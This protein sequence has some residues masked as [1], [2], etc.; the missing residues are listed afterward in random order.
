MES[1]G[2]DGEREGFASEQAIQEMER[3][4]ALMAEIESRGL[5]Q[6]QA[7]VAIL[8]E[9]VPLLKSAAANHVPMY[10]GDAPREDAEWIVRTVAELTPGESERLQI[11]FGECLRGIVSP[12]ISRHEG[13]L[14]CLFEQVADAACTI[15]HV[16]ALDGWCSALRDWVDKLSHATRSSSLVEWIRAALRSQESVRRIVACRLFAPAVKCEGARVA[17]T[18]WR[19]LMLVRTDTSSGVALA[20]VGALGALRA[21]GGPAM[22]SVVVLPVL[23]DLVCA[24]DDAVAVAVFEQLTDMC[25]EMTDAAAVSQESAVFHSEQSLSRSKGGADG[26]PTSLKS[27]ARLLCTVVGG[28]FVNEPP[29]PVEYAV[30]SAVGPLAYNTSFLREDCGELGPGDVVLARYIERA[31]RSANVAVRLRLAHNLPGLIMAFERDAPSHTQVLLGAH[32]S[33]ATDASEDVRIQIAVAFHEVVRIVGSKY[34]RALERFLGLLDD[35]CALVKDHLLETTPRILHSLI[36]S[37]PRT[38]PQWRST[39]K[40]L[41]VTMSDYATIARTD[42][43][44]LLRLFELFDSLT[45]SVGAPELHQTYIPLLLF[46]LAAGAAAIKRH[47]ARLLARVLAATCSAENRVLLSQTIVKLLRL[48]S[49]DSCHARKGFALAVGEIGRTFSARFFSTYLATPLGRCLADSQ[50]LVRD[51]AGVELDMLPEACRSVVSDPRPSPSTSGDVPASGIAAAK[52][53]GATSEGGTSNGAKVN[54][55]FLCAP[56]VAEKIAQM[57]KRQAPVNSQRQSPGQA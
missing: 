49:D 34:N 11:T 47:C 29:P 41:L 17:D 15:R 30:A 28:Y 32:A 57:A 31:G 16:S 56:N 51:A 20:F 25:A 4:N 3:A 33:L 24:H 23:L 44:K 52:H 10:F 40:S 1:S 54:D 42:W 8:R 46:H 12:A 21:V 27:T 36:G 13:L 55:E 26:S 6:P 38:S 53:D 5:S 22:T 14:D 37:L 18:L 19:D 9:G 43:R 39:T 7:A 2:N 50:A 45:S 35:P 48:G